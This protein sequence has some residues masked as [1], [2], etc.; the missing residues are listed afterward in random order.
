MFSER[1]DNV[2]G[3]LKINSAGIAGRR[4]VG[5]WFGKLLSPVTMGVCVTLLALLFNSR[6]YDWRLSVINQMGQG[7][8]SARNAGAAGARPGSR[9]VWQTLAGAVHR[10]DNWIIDVMYGVQDSARDLPAAK[11]V[12]LVAIDGESMMRVGLWPWSRAEV[13]RLLK[14]VSNAGVVG[15]DL[16]FN[17]PD[18]TSLG[19]YVPKLEYLY[20]APLNLSLLDPAELNN[21]L[22]LARHISS[23]TTVIGA[24]FYDGKTF[25]N[26]PSAPVVKYKIEIVPP[27]G[28]YVPLEKVMI[29]RSRQMITNIRMLRQDPS[30]PAG[31]G[32]MNL[33]PDP[34]GSMFSVP[35]FVYLEGDQA[36]PAEG[37]AG[38]MLSPALPLE[39]ARVALGGNGYRLFLGDDA[40]DLFQL[41]GDLR[42]KELFPIKGVS[43]VDN[44][45]FG[46]ETLLDIPLNELG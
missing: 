3:M 15:L 34:S 43:I 24:M 12:A 14:K 13:A 20:G 42:D 39:M 6:A 26:Q 16:I 32:F 36:D 9:R 17:E 33:F 23:A 45:S 18:P 44:M 5:Y 8:W 25:F 1:V 2:D 40:V 19:N 31:E 11:R 28:R 4:G 10:L 22:E 30:Q 27:L 38:R 35:L 41:S 29:R 46:Q 21:D 7:F 37:L